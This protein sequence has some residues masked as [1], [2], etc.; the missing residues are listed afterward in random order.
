M[1][2]YR[3]FN[4]EVESE[5]A[6]PELLPTPNDQDKKSTHS[7]VEITFGKV[8]P[9]GLD[10]PLKQTV[11]YQA[12][13]GEFWLNVPKVARYHVTQGNQITIEPEN[14]SDE[15]SVRVFLLGSCFGALLMQ[16]GL[17]LLHGNAIQIGKQAITF[18]GRSGAGKSTT[19]AIFKNR[20]YKILADDVCAINEKGEVIPSF[21]QVKLWADAAKKM[22]IETDGLRKIRP[23]VEKFALPL[24]LEQEY[25]GNTLPLSVVY[26][27]GTH[28]ED[29]I[30]IKPVSGAEK[31]NP[32]R[33]QTYRLPYIE[34]FDQAKR[35]KLQCI[36]LA[37]QVDLARVTRPNH[38][39]TFK[40]IAE[41]IETDLT[42]RGIDLHG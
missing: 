42:S 31:F 36:K 13:P 35:H 8:S 29:K 3:A 37:S 4:L 23:Q 14:G 30:E 1:Y 20:G 41:L 32:L 9:E 15:D 26:V 16:R 25:Q 38:K 24:N 12:K 21:P 6:F 40:E 39:Y 7:N 17:F 33:F 5:I 11:G 2:R 22:A 27:L 34:G 19:S 10:N 18:V 28:N